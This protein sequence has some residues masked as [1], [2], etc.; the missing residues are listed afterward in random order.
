MRRAIRGS[1]WQPSRSPSEGAYR[2]RMRAAEIPRDIVSLERARVA[3]PV[4][5]RG[6]GNRLELLSEPKSTDHRPIKLIELPA[7]LHAAPRHCGNLSHFRDDLS[8]LARA[9]GRDPRI[10]CH[11]NS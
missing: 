3:S 10:G 11:M 6:R 7:R 2:P 4:S 5:T 9:T 8:F 1:I